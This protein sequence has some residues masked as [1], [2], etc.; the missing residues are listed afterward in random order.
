MEVQRWLQ[1]D[2]IVLDRVEVS[3]DPCYTM[4]IY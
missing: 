3:L 2:R 1:D 4:W